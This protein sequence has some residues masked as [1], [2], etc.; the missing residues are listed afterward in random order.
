MRFKMLRTREENKKIIITNKTNSYL[1]KTKQI[2]R[3]ILTI[4]KI[5]SIKNKF[6]KHNDIIR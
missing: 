2:N 4:Y 5:K 6:R 3:M 1:N